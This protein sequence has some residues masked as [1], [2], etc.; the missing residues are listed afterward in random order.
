MEKETRYR[1][2]NAFVLTFGMGAREIF[3]M[4]QERRDLESRVEL[5]RSLGFKQTGQGLLVKYYYT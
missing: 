4:L 3:Q 5:Q 2:K 1:V